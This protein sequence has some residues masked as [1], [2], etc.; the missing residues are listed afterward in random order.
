[1]IVLSLILHHTSDG[2]NK[3]L[4]NSPEVAE[5]NTA[6]AGGGTPA[7]VAASGAVAGAGTATTTGTAAGVGATAPAG[8]STGAGNT[9]RAGAE[10]GLGPALT[11]SNTGSQRRGSQYDVHGSDN[12]S[13]FGD[14][15][16]LHPTSPV[17]HSGHP[18]VGLGLGYRVPTS[19]RASH[20]A[21]P[22][23]A[24]P[25]PSVAGGPIP[26]TVA[27]YGTTAHTQYQAFQPFAPNPPVQYYH[28][29]HF[30]PQVQSQTQQQYGDAPLQQM[31]SRW[32]HGGPHM[33]CT[34]TGAHRHTADGELVFPS[35]AVFRTMMA[36][37][38][39][40]ALEV[41]LLAAQ[42][43]ALPAAQVPE[44]LAARQQVPPAQ[45]ALYAAR[46]RRRSLQTPGYFVQDS[47]QPSGGRWHPREPCRPS[48]GP[49]RSSSPKP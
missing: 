36:H 3:R 2:S 22:Y 18:M 29:V 12:D 9:E 4:L 1:V 39:A 45:T 10:A 5:A 14:P 7:G 33:G 6:A 16:L 23:A 34:I 43:Q 31:N 15:F 42:G 48:S 8:T 25:M 44:V 20:P 17:R 24:A 11:A 26:Q 47:P 37:H 13:R 46:L 19:R 40:D 30:Q 32:Y 38:A 21:Q 28:P 27:G 49:R 35:T 41:G